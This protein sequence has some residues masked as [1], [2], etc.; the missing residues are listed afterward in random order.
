MLVVLTLDGTGYLMAFSS[1]GD[2]QGARIAGLEDIFVAVALLTITVGLVL[3]GM[4][5]LAVGEV[6][7]A[8]E[9]LTKGTLTDFLHAMRA[10]EAGN[11]DEAHARVDISAVMVHTRDEIGMMAASFNTMQEHSMVLARGCAMHV[12]N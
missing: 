6:A 5:S 4:I 7:K 8:A 11:L 2:Q 3:P 12:M 1:I 10:L 9:H